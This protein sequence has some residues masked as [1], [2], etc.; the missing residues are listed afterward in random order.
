MQQLTASSQV[1]AVVE[2][3][4]RRRTL[5]L[6]VEQLAIAVILVMGGAALMMLLGTQIL[7]GYWLVALALVG[8]GVAVSRVKNRLSDRY[9]LAQLLDRRLQLS[10]T[11]ST[12]WYL[13]SHPEI[14]DQA[15]T[16]QVSS[17]EQTA[18]GV[19]PE[20][21]LPFTGGRLW[22][23]AGIAFALSLGLFTVRYL[24]TESMSLKQSIIP[25]RIADVFEYIEKK[26]AEISGPK[27]ELADAGSHADAPSGQKRA[28]GERTK[29][30]G[31]APG[32]EAKGASSD[33]AA[34]NKSADQTQSPEAQGS[35]ASDGQSGKPDSSVKDKEQAGEK[36]A[37]ASEKS[38]STPGEN[39]SKEP[40]NDSP[41]N[42]NGLMDKMKDALSNMMSKIRP[43]TGAQKP[44]AGSQQNQKGAEDQKGADQQPGKDQNGDQQQ[45]ARN[46]QM[47]QEQNADGQQQGQSAEKAQ[48]SHGKD[49]QQGSDKKGSDAHSG[50]GHSD[51]EKDVKQA[52]QAKAMGKLAEIIG[53]RSATVSGDMTVETP[54]GKQR[55]QTEY[56]HAVGHHADLG[57]EINRD[58]V[59]VEDQQYVREY[60]E[61][62]RKQA[63]GTNK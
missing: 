33:Q 35:K 34:A 55:L 38:D 20:T 56:T 53:K 25:L 3:A 30:E 43:N 9:R 16:F 51:G 24:V 14:Q 13:R 36:S 12:A 28:E 22:V 46:Q 52:E 42:A 6:I 15:S 11:L 61:L 39:G 44:A 47:A 57:G 32:S 10:D 60:M 49:A 37:S 26:R 29:K 59:P 58:Q 18:L 62:A 17:A 31:N 1:E 40:K 50:A 54:S 8:I 63:H 7:A 19:M 45:S 21:V 2:Q 41:P 23:V 4:W 48:A 27:N 5:V